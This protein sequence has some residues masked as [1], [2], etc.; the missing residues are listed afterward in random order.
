[1]TVT[2]DQSAKLREQI[3]ETGPVTF[4][5]F[6]RIGYRS[7]RIQPLTE[8]FAH[9]RWKTPP[10]GRAEQSAEPKVVR[11]EVAFDCTALRAVG[12]PLNG[13]GSHIAIPP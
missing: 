1:M 2:T 4:N 13:L 12:I 8:A 5:D 10:T 3:A 9:R 6:S 11:N 7:A